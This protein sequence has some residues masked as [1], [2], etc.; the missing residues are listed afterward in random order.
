M[1]P[2]DFGSLRLQY[3]MLAVGCDVLEIGPAI[4]AARGIGDRAR[5]MGGRLEAGEVGM[6][7]DAREIWNGGGGRFVGC[8]P[9]RVL[10]ENRHGR[11]HTDGHPW[12][13]KL[14]AL[15]SALACPVIVSHGDSSPCSRG[16]ALQ[17]CAKI[18]RFIEPP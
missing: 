3:G 16:K 6:R 7:P 10:R 9:G 17:Q 12:S 11:E 14:R 15:P 13:E 18:A 8:G 5:A 4:G 1:A 2:D